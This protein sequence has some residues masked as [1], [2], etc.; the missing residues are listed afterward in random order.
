MFVS[1]QNPMDSEQRG[2]FRNSWE[3]INHFDYPVFTAVASPDLLCFAWLDAE[4]YI[5]NIY[6]ILTMHE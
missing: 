6:P 1:S 2:F 3:K 5:H 4:P